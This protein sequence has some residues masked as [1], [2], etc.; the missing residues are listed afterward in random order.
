MKW[1]FVVLSAASVLSGI[2]S[3]FASLSE[4]NLAFLVSGILTMLSGYAWSL[5]SEM[6]G[7]VE[8]IRARLRMLETE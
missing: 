1:V 7:E 8:S 2:L 5:V 4:W 6:W 3:V